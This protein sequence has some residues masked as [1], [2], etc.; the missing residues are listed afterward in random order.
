MAKQRLLD[1]DTVT[2]E[3]LF[4]NGKQY[5]VPL[6]QRD[7]AWGEEQWEALWQDVVESRTAEF[8]HYMGALVLQR[9][10][11][12]QYQVIDGQQRLATVVTACVAALD[13]ILERKDEQRFALLRARYVGSPDPGSLRWQSKLVLN[14]T[15]DA[16]FQEFIVNQKE[17]PAH[18]RLPDSNRRLIEARWYF[19]D[20]WRQLVGASATSQSFVD[21][22]QETMGTKLAFTTITVD[23]ELNAYSV[24]ETLNARNLQLTSTDLLK[25][26]LFSLLKGGRV[27]LEQAQRQW[28]RIVETVE[29]PTLPSFLRQFWVSQR[30]LV[31]ADRLFRALKAEVTTREQS[32]ALLDGMEHAAIGFRA[33]GDANDELWQDSKDCR[34]HVRTLN[35]LD[36]SQHVPLMLAC[37]RRGFDLKRLETV[38]RACLVVFMRHNVVGRR[39]PSELEQR[40]A[41]LAMAVT[42]GRLDSPRAIW[43]GVDGRDGLRESYASDEDFRA[44]FSRL[45]LARRGRKARLPRYLLFALDAKLGGPPG[46]FE[47]SPE[48]LEHVLPEN[49]SATWGHFSEEDRRRFTNRLGN[50]V[51]LARDEN[52]ALGNAG[53]DE[54]ARVFKASARPTTRLAAE[55]AAWT[56]QAIVS[57]QERLAE[58]AVTVWKFEA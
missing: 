31:R 10:V 35:L 40:F 17:P 42:D 47:T 36:V 58:A 7:Y 45:D 6:Y 19:K 1:T 56:A 27:D 23:D 3:T 30:K 29:A 41:H 4:S 32:F 50:Y 26:Y 2:L 33:L 39:N 11:K 49:P 12:E 28:R 18:A 13:L 48:T 55:P 25:N 52:R 5:L 22:F 46:D 44:D 37:L 54:K 9:G 20:C 15:D 14:E 16:F 34:E 21:A 51:L 38:L 24:F 43:L 53:F 57:R 8:P